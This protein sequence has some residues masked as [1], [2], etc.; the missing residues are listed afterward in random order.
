MKRKF[1]PVIIC[2]LICA[3][4]GACSDAKNNTNEKENNKTETA[5]VKKSNSKYYFKDDIIKVPEGTIKL[6]GSRIITP[7]DNELIYDYSILITVEFTNDSSTLQE[8]SFVWITHVS[9]FQDQ[10]KTVS[11]LIPSYDYA[12]LDEYSNTEDYSIQ[13]V[14]PGATVECVFAYR[15]TDTTSPVALVVMK[16]YN[17]ELGTKVYKLQ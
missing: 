8:P 2:F 14:K 15:L 11:Q 16:N 10:D 1:I 4:L 9:L 3:I 6:T 13:K 7:D 17:K 5:T 12:L